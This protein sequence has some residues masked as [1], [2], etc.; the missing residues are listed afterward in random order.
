MPIK[1]ITKA[2]VKKFATAK[3]VQ[4]YKPTKFEKEQFRVSTYKG[5]PKSSK[6]P[7]AGTKDNPGKTDIRYSLGK[8]YQKA[9]KLFSAQERIRKAASKKKISVRKYRRENPNNM[10]VKV[11]N[12]IMK[13]GGLKGK[14]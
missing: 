8:D 4:S 10:S 5:K 12:T 6:T 2:A 7:H 11:Y 9:S 13:Q 3:Q 14:K 1:K